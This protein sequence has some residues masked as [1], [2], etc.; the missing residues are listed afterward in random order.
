MKIEMSISELNAW[1][2]AQCTRCCLRNCEWQDCSI[3]KKN[4][5]YKEE[6]KKRGIVIKDE[7]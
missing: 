1:F 5:K 3:C 6:M 4:A 2:D 7:D